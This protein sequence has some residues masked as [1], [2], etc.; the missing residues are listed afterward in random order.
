MIKNYL[1]SLGR[2][3]KLA[4]TNKIQTSK[5]NKVLNDF[6][7]L[8]KQSKKNILKNNLKDVKNAKNRKIK[9]NLIQRLYLNSD[10]IDQIIKSIKLISKLKDPEN[11]F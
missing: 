2:K 7:D 4:F 1:N 10:K 5:K 6:A 8:L 11:Y 9:S 3:S